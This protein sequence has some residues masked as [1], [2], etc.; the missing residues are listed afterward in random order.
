MCI[1]SYFFILKIVPIDTLVNHLL[2]SYRQIAAF[3]RTHGVGVQSVGRKVWGRKMWG[4]KVWGRKVLG[5]KVLG[6]KV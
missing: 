2:M 3:M 5:R 1:V 6:R 4:R